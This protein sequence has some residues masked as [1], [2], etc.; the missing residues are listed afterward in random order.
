V[1]VH[2]TGTLTQYGTEFRKPYEGI[3]FAGTATATRWCGYMDGAG[4]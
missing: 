1:A 4:N 3:F 2:G